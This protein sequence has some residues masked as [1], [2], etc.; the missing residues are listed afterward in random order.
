MFRFEGY[1]LPAMHHFVIAFSDASQNFLLIFTEEW[2]VAG[3]HQESNDTYGPDVTFMC[4]F[5][6]E[7]FRCNVV[8]RSDRI[9]HVRIL[10]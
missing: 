3:E 1:T 8:R 5:A 7:N 9:V 4:V 6:I 2:R 10:L